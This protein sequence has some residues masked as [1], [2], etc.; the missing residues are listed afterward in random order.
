MILFIV[1]YKF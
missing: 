1:F